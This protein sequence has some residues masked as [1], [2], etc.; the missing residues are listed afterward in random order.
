MKEF[1][2]DYPKL[3]IAS[4]IVG[5]LLAGGT[6][7]VK[8]TGKAVAQGF[9]PSVLKNIG[10]GAGLG[11]VGGFGS[12]EGAGDRLDKAAF[13]GTLGG[14]IGG[15][16]DLL[17]RGIKAGYRALR[18]DALQ[19]L[20]NN[21]QEA[22]FLN[23]AMNN[24]QLLK[25]APEALKLYK[26]LKSE[27]YNVTPGEVLDH[28]GSGSMLAKQGDLTRNRESVV[29]T[30]LELLRHMD[31]KNRNVVLITAWALREAQGL[32]AHKLDLQGLRRT[33]LLNLDT[34]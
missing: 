17:S 11:A 26:Q 4:D 31:E 22:A 9:A 16:G 29:D 32:Q 27:G 18:P 14:A 12:G 25:D 7:I 19:K 33:L 1:R 23:E 24:E 5:G 6:G 13:G 30:V 28:L 3:A 2:E 15:A 10:V 34:N 21:P 20:S 8:N